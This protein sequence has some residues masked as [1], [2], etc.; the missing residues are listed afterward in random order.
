MNTKNWWGP[1]TFIFI[2]SLIGVGMIG[3]QTYNDAP[4]TATF[5]SGK[6]DELITKESIEQ[7]QIVFHKYALME[8][9]SF[10][11]DGAQRGPDFTAEA[12]H[13][14]SL[15]M[16]E[17]LAQ[18]FKANK[19]KDPPSIMHMPHSWGSMEIFRWQHFSS[20]QSY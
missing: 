10:F 20:L 16:N 3:Y 19:G 5:V 2:I 4:P 11:G 8:Y 13:Q 6:G 17:Y 14:V 1:L 18:Q 15:F 9:G 12:L 7:G